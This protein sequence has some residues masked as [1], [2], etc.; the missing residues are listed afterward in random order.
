M[1]LGKYALTRIEW[2]LRDDLDFDFSKSRL[3]IKES[4]RTENAPMKV[5]IHG[6]RRSYETP[7]HPV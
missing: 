5:N 2:H 1:V 4:E 3:E 6:N 7:N